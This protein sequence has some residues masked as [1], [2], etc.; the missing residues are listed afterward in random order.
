[1]QTDNEKGV[2]RFNGVVHGGS[3]SHVIVFPG[4]KFS[5]TKRAPDLFTAV[6]KCP[7]IF[8]LAHYLC[9]DLFIYRPF[10]V[11]ETTIPSQIQCPHS[12]VV[13]STT[14][15]SRNSVPDTP[16]L[17]VFLANELWGIFFLLKNW[18]EKQFTAGR[19]IFTST[20]QRVLQKINSFLQISHLASTR[21]L[22]TYCYSLR[23]KKVSCWFAFPY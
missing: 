7:A 23:S 16:K 15:F 6:I 9:I 12:S 11:S 2:C 19:C 21:W 20:L 4:R 5:R 8:A 14:N 18:F 17:S 13:D 10:R 22:S 1:M 3:V